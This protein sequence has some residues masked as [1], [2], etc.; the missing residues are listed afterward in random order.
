MYQSV[1][2]KTNTHAIQYNLIYLNEFFDCFWLLLDCNETL[3]LL[4]LIVTTVTV[5]V[6]TIMAAET[7]TS[8]AIETT[9]V[10]DTKTAAAPV[11][12]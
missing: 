4:L 3:V 7:T 2:R 1:S 6:T 8:A 12:L 11:S 9:A 5:S 10:K